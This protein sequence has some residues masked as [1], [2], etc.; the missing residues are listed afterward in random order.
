M[1]RAERAVL[2]TLTGQRPFL[3]AQQIHARLREG[4]S[5]VGLTSVYRAVQSL[6]ERGEIDE[7]RRPNG[8]VGYRRCPPAHHHHLTCERCG[9]TV[10]VDAPAAERSL[11]ALAREHGW[12]ATGHTIEI[13]GLC[14][15]CAAAAR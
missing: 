2:E 9:D 7:T 4:G 14:A 15:G 12:T 10:E 3:S 13:V 11:A 5:S 6:R 8:E 1:T